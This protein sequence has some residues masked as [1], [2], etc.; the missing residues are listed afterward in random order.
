MKRI[1]EETKSSVFD[2]GF[3]LLYSDSSFREKE[4]SIGSSHHSL[5][6]KIPM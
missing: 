6:V 1:K 2:D 5:T 4:F 3:S